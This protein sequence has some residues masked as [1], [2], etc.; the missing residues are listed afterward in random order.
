MASRVTLSLEWY[1]TICNLHTDATIWSTKIVNNT[2]DLTRPL[3]S[4]SGAWQIL[5]MVLQN[6]SQHLRELIPS[7][8][9]ESYNSSHFLLCLD[10]C[11]VHSNTERFSLQNNPP[12]CASFLIGQ[13]F[14][15]WCS[16][17]AKQFFFEQ[18]NH[19]LPCWSPPLWKP[20]TSL[21]RLFH[22]GHD[23]LRSSWNSRQNNKYMSTSLI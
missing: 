22:S 5:I 19:A 10:H 18:A 7:S 6:S 9:L 16:I 4:A 21:W 13:L 17:V 11:N 23:L 1:I 20:L 12:E 3:R 2:T 8:T 14:A 15:L